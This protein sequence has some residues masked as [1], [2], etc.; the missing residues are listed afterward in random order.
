MKTTL[1]HLLPALAAALVAAP[2][3]RAEMNELPPRP[4]IGRIDAVAA[5]T[6]RL[7]LSTPVDPE[8]IAQ[9]LG[10][11]ALRAAKPMLLPSQT[12]PGNDLKRP[13][14][15]ARRSALQQ[16]EN[17]LLRT[18][19]VQYD[20]AMEPEEA[21]AYLQKI[22]PLVE[23]AEPLYIPQLLATPNDPSYSAQ[24][25]MNVIKAP[26]GW[27]IEQG[28]STVVIGIIDSGILQSHEDLR[29]NIAT[30]TQE[31]PGNFV[32]DDGNGYVDDYQGYNLAWEDTS[33]DPGNTFG[34]GHGTAVA[35][36]AAARTDNSRGIAGVGWKVRF[37]P[38][39]GAVGAQASVPYG[40]DGIIYCA[41][42]GIQIANCSWGSFNYSLINQSVVDYATARGTLVVAGAGNHG[43]QGSVTATTPLYPAAYVG[44]VGASV[45]YTSDVMVSLSSYGP[46]A[47]IAAPA[48][49]AL[50]TD[51]N[52]QYSG[53]GATS[54][55]TPVISAA[56]ALIKSR[57]PGYSPAQIASVLRRSGD[58]IDDQNPQLRQMLPLRLNL[59]KALSTD[60]AAAP[61]LRLMSHSFTGTDGQPRRSFADGDTVRLNLTFSNEFADADDV[62]IQISQPS[63][64][65]GTLNTIEGAVQTVDIASGEEITL[66]PVLFV[67]NSAESESFVRIAAGNTTGYEETWLLRFGPYYPETRVDYTTF[68]NERFRYS[69]ADRGSLAFSDLSRKSVGDGIQLFGAG[70]QVYEAGFMILAGNRMVSTVR[71][72]QFTSDDDFEAVKE[73]VAP[74]PERGV[75]RDRTG[76]AEYIG[77]EVEHR[78]RPLRENGTVAAV[79][80]TV[81]NRGSAALPN[82][83]IGY[84][85]DWD[86]GPLGTDNAVGVF[87]D[88]PLARYAGWKGLTSL[89]SRNGTFPYAAAGVL[90]ADNSA[91][92]IYAGFNNDPDAPGT[93][94]GTLDG[95]SREDRKLCLSSTTPLRYEGTG[96]VGTVVGLRWSQP[97][98]AGESRTLT[99][100]FGL[101]FSKEEL[102]Q[103]L[104]DIG[105][106]ITDVRE[107]EQPHTAT[108]RSIA[109]QRGQRLRLQTTAQGTLRHAELFDMAGRS[110]K[111]YVFHTQTPS[112]ETDDLPAGCY[113]A[114]LYADDGAVH[115]RV[116]LVME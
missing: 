106:T 29:D 101:N 42:N 88:D 12:S 4:E 66:W 95:W 48:E 47:Q 84:F 10:W 27:D 74:E 69:A 63:S 89:T 85:F 22:S 50:T 76:A 35:G 17:K 9:A 82:L 23:V 113:I 65:F 83:A 92:P 53:F 103:Q 18:Y 108:P 97:V 99:L 54:A 37:F 44:A 49:G 25:M 57:Y 28:D 115:S 60:Y 94:F 55:A 96:D 43:D 15:T 40:Y 14:N 34:D 71:G 67:I 7:R 36:I 62:E 26:Q 111:K 41:A 112:I 75:V 70:N 32:D 58:N 64:R 79:D 20:A 6:I 52:G 38:L 104:L 56:A 93:P 1:T 24:E 116:I 81:T 21:C 13:D 86:I 3:A 91:E 51:N 107:H 39:K 45:T 30:R 98:P 46:H 2:Q 102:R 8:N 105:G 5:N 72:T 16:A 114:K 77:V 33:T 90:T 78:H 68:S 11:N 100:F 19:T 87:D 109:L 110:T 61:G 80:V 59:Q 31:I 73:Y